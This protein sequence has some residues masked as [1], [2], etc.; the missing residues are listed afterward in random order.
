MTPSVVLGL[1]DLTV[2]N[3]AKACESI[4]LLDDSIITISGIHS[5]FGEIHNRLDHIIKNLDASTE[6][7]RT[8]ESRIKDGDMASEMVTFTKSNI[9]QQA[10][11]TMLAQANS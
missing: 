4:T 5:N 7:L 1:S 11:Q 2:V 9:L 8:S 3:Q 6:N 10:A